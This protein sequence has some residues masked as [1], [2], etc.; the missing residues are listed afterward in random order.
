MTLEPP[1]VE[2]DSAQSP[3]R[4]EPSKPVPDGYNLSPLAEP[5]LVLLLC[6]ISGAVPQGERPSLIEAIF[7]SRD[8][9]DVVRCLRGSDAQTFVDVV[10]EV[11]YCSSIPRDDTLISL[12]LSL[13][14]LTDV[15]KSQSCAGDPKKMFEVTVRDMR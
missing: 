11:R 10:D 7:L 15:G 12:P 2:F 6:L 14:F 3:S 5:S 4:T 9:S 8:A 13:L 1:N